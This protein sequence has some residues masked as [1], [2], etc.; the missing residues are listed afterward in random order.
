MATTVKYYSS[1]RNDIFVGLRDI[2]L[3]QSAKA[4]TGSEQEDPKDV[5]NQVASD[6][7]DVLAKNVDAYLESGVLDVYYKG[8]TTYSPISVKPML[9]TGTLIA[10]ITSQ[11]KEIKLYAPTGGGEG[12]G[13][14]VKSVNGVSPD[15]LGNV[16]LNIPTDSTIRG[17]GYIKGFT[18]QDPIFKAHHAYN[19]T[20]EMINVLRHLHLNEDG[21]VYVDV[22]FYSTGG[23]SAFGIQ[24][25]GESGSNIKVTSLLSSGVQIATI[26]VDGV[27]TALYAPQGGLQL[28]E[29]STTAYRG[30]LGKIAYNHSQI[31]KGNPHGTTADML[32][33]DLSKYVKKEGDSI[34]WLQIGDAKFTWDSTNNALKLEGNLYA[35][36]GISAYGHTEG[37]VVGAGVT[38]INGQKGEL[39]LKTIN[40][41]TL[42]GSGN[43]TISDS[44][45]G[46]KKTGDT[47]TGSLVFKSNTPILGNA[48]SLRW[49][50]SVSPSFDNQGV[51]H[52]LITATLTGSDKY[53]LLGDLNTNLGTD[54]PKV[55]IRT[56]SSFDVR[57]L[58]DG[59][60]VEKVPLRIEYNDA[61]GFTVNIRGAGN[62]DGKLRIGDAIL[63]YDSTNKALYLYSATT[64]ANMNLYA[65]GGISAYGMLASTPL[66]TLTITGQAK[67]GSLALGSVNVT[68]GNGVLTIDKAE[69][70]KGN[71]RVGGVIY[72]EQGIEV[73]KHSPTDT[74]IADIV[75]RTGQE[76]SQGM[77]YIYVTIN[78][79][80]YRVN[81]Y[82]VEKVATT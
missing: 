24:Q 74:L 37:S 10:T 34:G 73:G 12:G 43:I 26:E 68:D 20:A 47:M 55:Y 1:F 25:G 38:S 35:T 44:G 7:A 57:S 29:T 4:I 30:D 31:T 50:E 22:D 32:G 79:E 19:V 6:T 52:S 21:K 3:K 49:S 53:L 72:A 45:D 62:N 23:I 48:K 39:T 36:G 11:G 78:G 27:P 42:L 67:V 69:L 13:G 54:A 5:I 65:T 14:T 77:R 2:Y 82:K 60:G 59:T 46:V 17:W 33:I 8:D 66:S 41:Q 56:G 51:V 80:Y 76:S 61:L 15:S 75:L 40:N 63:S 58:G 64:G 9:T 71:L 81:C 16:K 70:I 28:G 18:E